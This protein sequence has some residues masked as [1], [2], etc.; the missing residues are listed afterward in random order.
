MYI[1]LS[2]NF[3]LAYIYFECLLWWVF[4]FD[5]FGDILYCILEGRRLDKISSACLVLAF[6][7]LRLI[8]CVV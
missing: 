2:F 6:I 8:S 1:L 5:W 4:Y 3:L 7:G